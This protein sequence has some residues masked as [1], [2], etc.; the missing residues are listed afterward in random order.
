LA[1]FA[2]ERA[3]ALPGTRRFGKLPAIDLERH[4]RRALQFD[5]DLFREPQ[6]HMLAP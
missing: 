4:L 2:Q 6:R 1:E 3:Q 5:A